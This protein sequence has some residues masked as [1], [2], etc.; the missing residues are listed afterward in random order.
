MPKIQQ[1]WSK[2]KKFQIFTRLKIKKNFFFKYPE[3]VKLAQSGFIKYNSVSIQPLYARYWTRGPTRTT[4]KWILPST[5]NRE[6][7]VDYK[8]HNL[9]LK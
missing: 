3:S 5:Q 6:K 4:S 9:A 7:S 2:S 8:F 1:N